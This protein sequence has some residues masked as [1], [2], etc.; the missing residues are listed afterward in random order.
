[1]EKHSSGWFSVLRLLQDRGVHNT[2]LPVT[3][4]TRSFAEVVAEKDFPREG[5]CG[6]CKVGELVGVRVE[7]KGVKE[8]LQHL[9]R[10]IVFRFVS[11]EKINWVGFRSWA[12]RNWGVSK[13]VTIQGIGDGLWLL[14]CGSKE[15]VNMILSIKRW[16]FGEIPL[17]VD[18]WIKDAGR[19]SV[20]L[21]S[22]IAWLSIRGITL[23][24]RSADLFRELGEACGEFMDVV[25][26]GNLSAVRIKVRLKG[27][28]PEVILICF[29]DEVFL[30][31][32]EF[33]SLPVP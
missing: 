31:R 13:E 20:L 18:I 23:H 29:R 33:D 4:G 11:S 1:M 8:R 5:K 16:S 7:E 26:G 3:R 17:L 9:D 22:D 32:V 14:A 21:A 30:V 6:S 28:V 25:D 24:L 15:E 19:S 12:N 10:C 2:S 27:M